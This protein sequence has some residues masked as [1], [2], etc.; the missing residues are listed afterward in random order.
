MFCDST[1]VAQLPAALVDPRCSK[2]MTKFNAQFSR[3]LAAVRCD[4]YRSGKFNYDFLNFA[5]YS[6]L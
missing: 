6:H 1:R 2:V 4:S 3:T 5:K